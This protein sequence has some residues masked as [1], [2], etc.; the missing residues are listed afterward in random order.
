MPAQGKQEF[1]LVGVLQNFPQL[2]EMS[3]RRSLQ[4][5]AL[6]SSTQGNVS[7]LGNR[8]PEGLTRDP[9]SGSPPGQ[10]L[11]SFKGISRQT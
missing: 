7:C 6:I 8:R 9:T 2:M 4:E 1:A 5:F 10:G 11:H 3:Q